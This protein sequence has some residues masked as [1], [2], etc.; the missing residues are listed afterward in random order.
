[1]RVVPKN[2]WIRLLV[3]WCVM[4]V[5]VGITVGMAIIFPGIGVWHSAIN[6]LIAA[7]LVFMVMFSFMHLYSSENLLR[8][9]AGMGFFWLIFMF[10]LGLADY[11]SRIYH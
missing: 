8:M 1:M 10:T 3:T 9:L 2:P 7:L 11:F 4:L 5:L 6:L